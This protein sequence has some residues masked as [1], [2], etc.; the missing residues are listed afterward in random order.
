[1]NPRS[2]PRNPMLK[3]TQVAAS[4]R[5]CTS[6]I[7]A[8]AALA[9]SAHAVTYSIN[10]SN[11]KTEIAKINNGDTAN[12]AAG[13][14]TLSDADITNLTRRSAITLN[15]VKGQTVLKY[16]SAQTKDIRFDT[17]TGL[18]VRNL[19]FQDIYV[20]F[21]NCEAHLADGLQF[22]ASKAV[23]GNTDLCGAFLATG[24]TFQFCGVVQN[25]GTFK[26][27][28]LKY[29]SH[30]RGMVKNCNVKGKLRGAYDLSG[31]NSQ[32][33]LSNFGERFAGGVATF[34]TED[35]ATY[36]HEVW[37]LIHR[38]NTMKGWS[39]SGSGGGLKIKNVETTEVNGNTYFTSGIL[40]RVEPNTGS[41]FRNVWIHDNKFNQGDINIWMPGFNPAQVRINNNT[42]LTGEIAA[43]RD[44][45]ATFNNN[46]GFAANLPGGVYNNSAKKYSLAPV[47]K[48]SGNKTL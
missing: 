45:I 48:Q 3:R 18:K 11:F 10:P 46:L 12:F 31:A 36:H 27:K 47:I 20:Y 43:T 17:K 32:T 4:L 39:N 1:M 30:A 24:G 41:R 35:H 13:S 7:L 19:V 8:T 21:R 42:V 5:S 15:G 29:F 33:T 23:G 26:T 28:G 37:S 38:S 14:Y 22:N 6:L 2:N 9:V 44:V 34:E 40:G 16:N 25:L